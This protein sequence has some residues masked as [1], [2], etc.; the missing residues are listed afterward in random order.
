MLSPDDLF[1]Q[2][3]AAG[4]LINNTWRVKQT[5]ELDNKTNHIY[6]CQTLA[7]LE[8]F[9]K[10]RFLTED[11]SGYAA[12]RWRNFKRHEAWLALIFEIVPGVSRPSKAFHKTQDFF[13]SSN[14]ERIPFDLKVTRYP[15]TAPS[16]LADSALAEWFYENQSKQGRFHMA[17]RFFIVGDPEAILYDIDI[18][19]ASIEAF[20]KQ[21]SR[22]R[23]FIIKPGART[24]RAVVIRLGGTTPN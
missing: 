17:N 11:E 1:S 12:H 21:M 6:N 2:I 18:A 16:N 4:L 14:G 24:S 19:R 3:K 15:K 13:I 20:A 8:Y 9:S 23:H 10:I 5:D 22:Y 7:D